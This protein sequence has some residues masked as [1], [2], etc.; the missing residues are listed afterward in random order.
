MPDRSWLLSSIVPTLPEDASKSLGRTFPHTD[1]NGPACRETDQDLKKSYPASFNQCTVEPSM[2][3]IKFAEQ[4]LHFLQILLSGSALNPTADIDRIRLNLTYS[5]KD[6]FGAEPSR[7]NDSS[8]F[9]GSQRNLPVTRL[10]GASKFTRHI[11][12]EQTS[13]DRIGCHLL[14]I[15]L[16]AH[17][18]GLDH[19]QPTQVLHIIGR[20][21]TMKLDRADPDCLRDFHH[22]LRT[23][24]VHKDADQRYKRWQSFHQGLGLCRLDVT[25]TLF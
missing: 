25:R 1:R 6:V 24:F 5:L 22:A 13:V 18:E 8:L 17:S 9:L 11:S 21:R 23:V 3:T 7:Q 19:L 16:V 2:S 4:I 14:D 20:L 12:V 15:E 10:S